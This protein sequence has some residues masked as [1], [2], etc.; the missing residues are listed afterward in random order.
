MSITDTIKSFIGGDEAGTHLTEYRCSD[1]GHTFESAKTEDRAQC[2][3]CLS[4]DV[5]PTS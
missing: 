2:M 4:T 3:E 5:E 1:C